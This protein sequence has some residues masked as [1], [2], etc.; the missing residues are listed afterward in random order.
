MKPISEM[1]VKSLV[2]NGRTCV[3]SNGKVYDVTDFVA[4]HPGGGDILK[5]HSGEDVTQVMKTHDSHEHSASAYRI[6]DK[7]YIGDIA[8]QVKIF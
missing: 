8:S 3:L 6:L 7:Y 5:K 2:N 4:R 1:A